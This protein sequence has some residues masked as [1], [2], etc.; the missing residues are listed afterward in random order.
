MSDL[1]FRLQTLA[2]GLQEGTLKEFDSTMYALN[3]AAERIA[4]LEAENARLLMGNRDALKAA[5]PAQ[6][7]RKPVAW[8]VWMSFDGE[9]QP[10]D[11]VFFTEEGAQR[12]QA[13]Y[14]GEIVPLYK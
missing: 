11:P 8:A 5:A 4:E 9:M 2:N 3:E 7:E 6:A 10:T 12:Q 14:G 1:T 13:K